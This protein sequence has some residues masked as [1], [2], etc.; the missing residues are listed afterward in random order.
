[1]EIY[2]VVNVENL[3]FFEP[4]MIMDQGEKVSIPSVD[5]FSL[6]YLDNLKEDI[7]LERRMG[8]SHKG[9]VDYI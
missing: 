4:P 7:I 9:D 5:E 6:E 1:M 3:K 8:N 2:S